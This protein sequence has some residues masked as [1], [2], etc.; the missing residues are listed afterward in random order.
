MSGAGKARNWKGSLLAWGL[1]AVVVVLIGILAALPRPEEQVEAEAERAVAVR[2]LELAPR[3]M[4]DEIRL[5]GRI[6]PL[7][8]ALLPAERAGRV[9]E[10]LVD[11]GAAVEAG[12][13]LVRVDRRLWEAAHRRAAIERRDAER[14]LQRWRELEKTG[15]VSASDFEAVS[16]RE[17][18]ARIAVDETQVFLD[19]C[20]VRAPFAGLIADR[21]VELGDYA[22]EG[23]AVL[24]LIRL[25]RVKL[26]FDVPERDIGAVAP[27]QEMSFT[28]AALPGRE[29]RG[30]VAFVAS[31]AARESN[32]FAVELEV[33]NADGALK[34]GMIA[35]VGL[36]RR[37]REAAVV[38]PLAAVVPRKGEH[39][40]FVVEN[41]RAV[42]KRVQIAAL[43]GSEAV[44][45]GGLALGEQVVVEGHRGLQDGLKVAVAVA[46]E[47]VPG[48]APTEE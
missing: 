8:A 38:V 31:Q 15:A 7:Q 48:P 19:Q 17:E 11:K 42:R 41:G 26:A 46:A 4:P 18:S 32:S 35:Q 43:I 16:R 33:D 5:P 20:E 34:A 10:L 30:T 14:D 1:L 39:Y 9:V 40:V 2:V 25:D 22:N 28:L 45:E 13:M 47:P 23:Q 36:V 6:E 27:G 29:F 37:V 3:R 24:R 44:I 12:Q 21:L